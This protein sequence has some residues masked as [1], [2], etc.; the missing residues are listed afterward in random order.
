MPERIF[1]RFPPGLVQG[2]LTDANGINKDGTFQIKFSV[3]K[4]ETG[5]SPVWEKNM[6]S[7]PIKNGNFQVILQGLGDNSVQ[8]ENAVRDLEAA[9][10]EIKVGA[11][12]PLV[13]RQLL[14]RSP[15]SSP[16]VVSGKLDVLIQSDNQIA[17]SGLIAMRTGNTDRLII[18]NNGNVGIGV[19]NPANAFEVAG[20]AAFGGFVDIGLETVSTIC[21]YINACAV[22]CPAGKKV[23]GGGCQL[24]H[25]ASNLW[26][27]FPIDSYTWYCGY[28]DWIR[29]DVYVY[30]ICARV[31]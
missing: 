8:I 1:G 9:Y 28:T 20:N 30:A 10:V 12:A 4:V 11:E 2:R 6:P 7:V 21:G 13:P 31:K 23:L 24:Q 3:F 15:F 19:V 14:L 27:S 17:G 22:R 18:L 5:G 16:A 26:R 25:V 29:T